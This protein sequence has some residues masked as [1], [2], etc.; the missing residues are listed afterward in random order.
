MRPCPEPQV[1]S[2][3]D[4]LARA[5]LEVQRCEVMLRRI[6]TAVAPMIAAERREG[7]SHA[8]Q[9]I[10]LLGQSLADIATCLTGVAGQLPPG[11]SV[12]ARSLLAPL[13]LDDLC[14]RLGGLMAVDL[15]PEERIALF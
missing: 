6:E 10:D 9:D 7:C 8:L 2:A 1:Q 3:G 12:D 4:V 15:R 13:R 11:A 5:A 14:Q